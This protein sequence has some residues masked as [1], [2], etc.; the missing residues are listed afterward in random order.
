MKAWRHYFVLGLFLLA[1]GALSTRVVFLGV[2]ERDFLQQEGDARSIRRESIPALRGVIYDRNGD[3]LA[4]ST[5]VYAVSTNPR[6]ADFDQAQ[7]AAMSKVLQV[8]QK[9]LERRVQAHSDKQFVY[10]KRHA[11]WDMSRRL[12]ALRLPHLE[13]R[14]EYRRY[15]PAAEIAAHVTGLTDIDDQGIEG[16]ELAFERNLRGQPGAKIV[17]KD[18]R[19]NSIRDL[20][21][22]A[23]PRFGQ[24]VS[25]SIDLRLQYIAYREL[26]SAVQVHKAESA[27]LIMADA[28]TGEILALVN[29]PSYNPND[30][31]GQLAGMRNRAVTDSYEPGSTVKPFTALAALESDRYDTETVIDT[32]PGYFRVGGKL[33][34]DPINR[35]SLSLAQAIQKSSQVAIAKVALDLEE[36]AVFDVLARAGLGNFISSGLPGEAMGRFSNSQLRYPVVRATLAYGYGLSVTPLQLTGAYLTLASGG[37]RIPLSILKQDRQTETEQVFD[38]EHV[39]Q[40][41]AMMELV[42]SQAGT[43]SKAAVPGYRVAGK[44]GTARIVGK[45][46]YDDER[47]VAWFAGMVPVSDPRLVMIVLVNE[48]RS[49]VNSGGGV[50]APIFGRVAERSVRVLGI[51]GDIQPP[52][53]VEQGSGRLL[54]SAGVGL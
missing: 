45:Q 54:S 17:L 23:P 16:V 47:H 51:A 22:L 15:Y 36:Q 11:G 1:V 6:K 3:A 20:D 4:V 9:Q 39:R 21:Y 28:K 7:F 25:L 31:A 33:I 13:L 40:V 44:T 24:D 48:P 2:T 14:P 10:L 19:G 42:T 18:R 38:P 53:I 50:A 8:P 12:D 35:A 46:G 43:A 52:S 29:Q 5:P 49:G 34:Q 41:L 26:K 37:K 32:S 30:I 27:S